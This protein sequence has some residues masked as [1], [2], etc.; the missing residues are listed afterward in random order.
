M[1]TIEKLNKMADAYDDALENDYCQVENSDC[2]HNTPREIVNKIIA[3]IRRMKDDHEIINSKFL[4][5]L[6]LEDPESGENLWHFSDL[7]NNKDGS[8]S[9]DVGSESGDRKLRH[10]IKTS[11]L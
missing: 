6:F 4:L 9:F 7:T 8:Y 3:E 5:K 10:T 2:Y 11:E 1:N